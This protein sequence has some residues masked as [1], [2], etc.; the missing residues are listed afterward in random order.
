MGLSTLIDALGLRF[1]AK[2]YA[3]SLGPQLIHDYGGSETYN[4]AQIRSA[5]RKLKLPERHIRFGFAAFMPESEFKK[6]FVNADD[7]V[8]LR[9]LYRRFVPYQPTG[10]TGEAGAYRQSATMAGSGLT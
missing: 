7:Y 9:D 1:A 2:K 8:L 10:E 5:V 3:R 6:L 4:E